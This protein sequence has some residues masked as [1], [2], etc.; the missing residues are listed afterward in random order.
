MNRTDLQALSTIRLREA[1]F[2]LG[3]GLYDGAYYLA[4]YAAEC[5]LTA[6]I[7]RATRRYEFPDRARVNAC[8]T[9]DI[10]ELL[11]QSGLEAAV[12]TERK[13]D[14]EFDRNWKIVQSWSE[15]SRYHRT[16][17]ADALELI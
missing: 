14:L 1:K 16:A 12:R 9:H 8:H 2:L 5:A 13:T 17:P 7:A 15:R 11:K 6:C 4:G 10:A 3:A